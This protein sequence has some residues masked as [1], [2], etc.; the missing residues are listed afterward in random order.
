MKNLLNKPVDLKLALALYVMLLVLGTI[1][2]GVT[3]CK[4]TKQIAAEK[5]RFRQ[6]HIALL[7]QTRKEHPCDTFR[8]YSTDTLLQFV[9][10]D[11][12][13]VGEITYTQDT[14]FIKRTVTKF[15]LDSAWLQQYRDSLASLNYAFDIAREDAAVQ[16]K[17]ADKAEAS[18]KAAKEDEAYY[19]KIVIIGGIVLGLLIGG[20]GAL[21]IFG[22]I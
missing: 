10:G 22:K 20:I 17:R 1:I 5:E 16:T 9:P 8:T 6:E 2:I 15:V 11:T 13:R 3:S 4:T 19:K 21:K 18:E 14:V 7:E 12:V